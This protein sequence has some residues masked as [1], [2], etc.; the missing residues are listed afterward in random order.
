M[1]VHLANLPHPLT[2]RIRPLHL[3]R[4]EWMLARHQHPR[5]Y[6]EEVYVVQPYRRGLG[7]VAHRLEGKPVRLVLGG[8][9][10]W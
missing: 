3:L 1:V 8:R 6:F 9:E 7:G 2:G 10:E 5:S 4:L